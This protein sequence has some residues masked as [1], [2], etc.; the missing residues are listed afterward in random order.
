MPLLFRCEPDAIFLHIG[1]RVGC[2]K[3]TEINFGHLGACV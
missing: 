1:Y 3:F 2:L